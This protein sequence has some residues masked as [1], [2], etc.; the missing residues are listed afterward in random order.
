MTPIPFGNGNLIV[1]F[2]G[3]T[4]NP[5]KPVKVYRNLH[6]TCEHDKYSIQ[7]HGLIVAHTSQI[8]LRNCRFVINKAGQQ[9]VR[10]QK[11]KNVHAFIVGKI[12]G[13]YGAISDD[14]RGLDCPI[15]YNPYNND[16]FVS[17]VVKPPCP[18]NGAV[19]VMINQNGVSA[20][21][22]D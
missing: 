3:R 6:A 18:V 21:C 16:T 19:A 15:T 14:K 2:K 9:R 10:E 1:P 17:S 22:L 13:S 12:A 5:D 8:L 11:R 4:I 7:Q 20:T